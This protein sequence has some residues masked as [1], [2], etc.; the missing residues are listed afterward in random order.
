MRTEFFVSWTVT[1]T[2]G[3]TRHYSRRFQHENSARVKMLAVDSRYTTDIRMG[4]YDIE[5]ITPAYTDHRGLL[6]PA[7]ECVRC[8]ILATKH[9]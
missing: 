1:T 7:S 4:R 9:R 3:K 8:T 5:T 6:H 2:D